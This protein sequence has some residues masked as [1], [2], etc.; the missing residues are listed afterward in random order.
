MD[1]KGG[2]GMKTKGPHKIP[3][4]EVVL[5]PPPPTPIIEPP[6]LV[7]PPT[8]TSEQNINTAG[9][10]TINLMWESTQSRIATI[11][12]YSNVFINAVVICALLFANAKIDTALIALILAAMASMNQISGIIIG[13]YFSR[14]NHS[15]IG[16]I[17][18]KESPSNLGTR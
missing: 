5:P 13:F 7:L 16:G 11:T 12:V 1:Y 4:I 10:R 6:K 14:T 18:P 2:D 17:G 9:Q 15:A 3:K 8:T